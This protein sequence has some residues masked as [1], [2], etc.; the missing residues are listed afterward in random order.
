MNF[1]NFKAEEMDM[2]NVNYW[3][4]KYSDFTLC[5]RVI[6][7]AFKYVSCKILSIIYE[8]VS[9]YSALTMSMVSYPV[10]V[11]KLSKISID[12]KIC[13]LL[14]ILNVT[15]SLLHEKWSLFDVVVMILV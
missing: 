1:W 7:W 3:M 11:S 6:E 13:P 2:M 14:P 15:V 12:L 5:C 9:F 8:K 4:R 10:F